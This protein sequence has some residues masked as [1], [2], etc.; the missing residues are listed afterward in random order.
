MTFFH[1]SVK[2]TEKLKEVQTQLGLP[3]RKLIQEVDTR[4]N[5]TFFM[6]DR[7]NEQQ[8][9][10]TT[11]LC[12]S[13]RNDLCLTTEDLKLLKASLSVLQPFE[14]ATREMSADQFL[15][16]SKAIPLARSLQHITAESTHEDTALG[17]MLSIQMRRRFT[18]VER[19]HLLAITTILDP[20]LKKLAFSDREAGHQAENWIIQEAKAFITESN[21]EE[22][23]I[24]EGHETP[25][26]NKP[27]GLWDLFDQKVVDYQSTRNVTD[28]ASVEA[29]GYLTEE[30][31]PRAEDPLAWWKVNE[32]RFNCLSNLAR[33]YL[34]IP[35]TSVPS[36]RLFSKAGE[37]VS[38]RRS[39]LKPKKH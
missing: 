5:S 39:R 6:F 19:A 21:M 24:D 4:W 25:K 14:S 18:A 17:A 36:E 20:R 8:N 38:N 26:D 3:E 7:I 1:Q 30:V 33:K 28:K 37:L 29:K 15:S 11:A 23:Q 22:T 34:C 13:G 9:A 16:L 32:K 2:A 31:L 10:I 27:P 35:G 12:L